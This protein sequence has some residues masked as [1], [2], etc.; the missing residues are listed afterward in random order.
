MNKKTEKPTLNAGE[1]FDRK[2]EE[3]EQKNDVA[4]KRFLDDQCY[5]VKKSFID[6]SVR[7]VDSFL[8]DGK[9]DKIAMLAHTLPTFIGWEEV[10]TKDFLDNI[11]RNDIV[12]IQIFAD[13]ARLMLDKA[14]GVYGIPVSKTDAQQSI[15]HIRSVMM[16]STYGAYGTPYTLTPPSY[17]LGPKSVSLLEFQNVLEKGDWLTAHTLKSGCVMTCSRVDEMD[18]S[19]SYTFVNLTKSFYDEKNHFVDLME[20]E[21]PRKIIDRL[22]E[23]EYILPNWET[24]AVNVV[25][26]KPAGFKRK[27]GDN[28]QGVH[29]VMD[30]KKI[31]VR[32]EQADTKH[33]LPELSTLMQRMMKRL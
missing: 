23:E 5:D 1:Y 32:K 20:L 10:E 22:V 12:S 2:M 16:N 31:R 14:I 25:P 17:F 30:G 27:L 3:L 29:F 6:L 33:N 24:R 28:P 11:C 9:L 13:C 19:G 21:Y 7:V 26:F 4:L 8:T 15:R 18:Y